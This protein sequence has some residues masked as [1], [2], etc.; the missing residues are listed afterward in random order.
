MRNRNDYSFGSQSVQ[1]VG[2]GYRGYRGDG[3]LDYSLEVE[4]GEV[5]EHEGVG[6]LFLVAVG[7]GLDNHFVA[8]Y[9]KHGTAG[10]CQHHGQ[11]HQRDATGIKTNHH[12]H[13]LQ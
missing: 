10:K 7:M 13:N 12:A 3:L 4:E 8:D 1:R 2:I 11:E 9:I 5:A 6:G